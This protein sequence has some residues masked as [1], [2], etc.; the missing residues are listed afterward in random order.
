MTFPSDKYPDP[1]KYASDYFKKLS[2]ATNGIDKDNIAEAVSIL[3][4]TFDKNV[5]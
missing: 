3:E 5:L 1:Q 4:N 2:E